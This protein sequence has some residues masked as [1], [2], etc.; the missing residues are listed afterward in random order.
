LGAEEFISH[1]DRPLAMWERQ[2]RVVQATRKELERYEAESRAGT[3][4]RLSTRS[5]K[6]R[7]RGCCG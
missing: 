3:R 6:K 5:E 7:K 2:E 1:P 4:S